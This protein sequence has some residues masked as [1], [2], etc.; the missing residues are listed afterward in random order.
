[1][2]TKKLEYEITHIAVKNLTVVWRRS[3]RPFNEAWANKIA[4]E[5]DPDK[6]EP[7]VVTK[8]NGEGKFHI[9]EGQHRKAGLEKALGADQ[10]APCRIVGE[11]D[12]ARAAEIWLG[13]NKGRKAPRPLQEFMVAVEAKREIEV[14]INQVVK[15]TG[16]RIGDS[17]KGENTISAVGALRKVYNNYG[18]LVL[19]N[20]LDACRLLWGSDPGGVAGSIITGMGMF[21]NEFHLYVDAKHL[22]KAITGHYNAPWKFV[23]A[24]RL[25]ADKSSETL[26]IAMSELLRFRY[27]RGVRDPSKR[28]RRKEV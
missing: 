11:A 20:T 13:I 1:M 21:L 24:S 7:I 19:R 28:L 9:V 22:R 18:E 15:R 27:N 6:F 17:I 23:D 4:E 14:A 26:D 10:Q 16:Y 25:E 2:S 5:F 12:P 3:Q 8:P